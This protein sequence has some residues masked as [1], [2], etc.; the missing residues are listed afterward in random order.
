MTE[1]NTIKY[2]IEVVPIIPLPLQR[3]SSFTY[4]YPEPIGLGS[5]VRVPFVKRSIQGVVIGSSEMKSPLPFK[6]RAVSAIIAPSFLTQTQLALAEWI[7]VEYLT[8]LGLVL[9]HAL[10]KQVAERKK[11]EI[12][13]IPCIEIPKPSVSQ[14]KLATTL[15][16]TTQ[17][18]YLPK[19]SEEKNTVFLILAKKTIAAKK[20]ILLLVPDILLAHELF[21]EYRKYFE[22]GAVALI[23]SDVSDGIYSTYWEAIRSGNAHIIIG[24]R[25][26]LFAPFQNLETILLDFDSHDG[27]KQWDMMPR[28]EGHAVA[29]KLATL[30]KANLITVSPTQMLRNFFGREKKNIPIH[31]ES[32]FDDKQARSRIILSDLKLDRY[33]KNFSPFSLL[34]IEHVRESLRKGEQILLIVNRQG[35]S[36]FSV[37][38]RCKNV[39]RCPECERALVGTD[40]G[41]YRCLHCSYH[42]KEFPSCPDCRGINF[43]NMGFGTEKLERELKRLFPY[44]IIRRM[45]A[46]SR[47][48]KQNQTDILAE[49][50]SGKTNILI[51]TE[52]ALL[53]PH[54]PKLGLVALLDGDNALRFPDYQAEERLLRSLAIALS[55]VSAKGNLIIQT[56]HSEHPIFQSLTT[57]TTR[58]IIDTLKQDREMFAYPPYGA[59]IKCSWSDTDERKVEREMER[60]ISFL[61]TPTG[62]KESLIVSE[63]VIPLIPKVRGKYT[64]FIV[65]RVRGLLIP[66]SLRHNL[67][68]LASLGFTIDRNP[69]S[70]S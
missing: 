57:G 55:R 63:Q 45:D 25:Q 48:L 33:K 42:T 53:A 64:R 1:K 66:E 68:K 17:S 65:I 37:C 67:A 22:T 30:H 47:R 69:L 59:L 38:E 20:Q 52:A 58:S 18:H 5:L 23:T 29:E 43:K 27:Y 60:A 3:A 21:G 46:T 7:G 15:V 51:G 8:P 36:I 44:S 6:T 16:E 50:H 11:K 14:K 26:A 2:A 54:L 12:K 70:L 9:K 13:N 40:K 56:F 62:E 28:Y 4:E 49:A 41:S 24:T 10:P 61:K 34:T 19:S 31:G 39:L 35:T 32:I